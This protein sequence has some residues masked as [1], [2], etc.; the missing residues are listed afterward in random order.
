MAVQHCKK[1]MLLVVSLKLM[2]QIY[3]LVDLNNSKILTQTD[4][5]L[6]GGTI[7]ILDGEVML[8]PALT[9]HILHIR[10][11]LA[12]ADHISLHRPNNS[13]LHNNLHQLLL[14]HNLVL[15]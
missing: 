12:Q 11:M 4:T 10:P 1:L 3:T 2:Q 14:L 7:Q 9:L 15:H 5:I 13:N 6:V 8:L